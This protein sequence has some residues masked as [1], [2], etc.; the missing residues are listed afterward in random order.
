MDTK[1]LERHNN[2]KDTQHY[3][4]QPQTQPKEWQNSTKPLKR[5][6]LT[7]RSTK[8]WQKQ[9]QKRPNYPRE[10]RNSHKITHDYCRLL[11]SANPRKRIRSNHKQQ[12][13]EERHTTITKAETKW[14]Q[15]DTK[16]REQHANT[17]KGCKTSNKLQRTTKLHLVTANTKKDPANNDTELKT[18]RRDQTI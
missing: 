9:L 11:Y 4:K 12:F 3:I 6:N 5:T 7:R 14:A 8:W 10:T 17:T 15:H 2:H 18:D 16:P 13:T 1:P